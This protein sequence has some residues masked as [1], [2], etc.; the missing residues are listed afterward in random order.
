MVLPLSEIDFELDLGGPARS[1]EDQAWRQSWRIDWGEGETGINPE[2]YRLPYTRAS[3][4]GRV[5]AILSLPDGY[6]VARESRDIVVTNR[7]KLELRSP[8]PDSNLKPYGYLSLSYTAYALDGRALQDEA[9]QWTS[10][11]EGET[12]TPLG[13]DKHERV[14]IPTTLGPWYLKAAWDD[15]SGQLREETFAFTIKK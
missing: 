2:N 10:S 5:T 8:K 15:G 6:E 3:L 4:E 9:V 12:W 1:Q 13:Q 7:A 11:R 14:R